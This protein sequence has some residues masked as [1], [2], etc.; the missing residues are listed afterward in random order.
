MSTDEG[1]EVLCDGRL[2]SSM[3]VL[4]SHVGADD[5]MPSSSFMVSEVLIADNVG[6]TMFSSSQL[7]RHLDFTFSGL[8]S[9]ASLL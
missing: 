3:L 2:G 8:F 7:R 6:E 4:L 9:S 1:D 5:S